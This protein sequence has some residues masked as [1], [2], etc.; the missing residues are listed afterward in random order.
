MMEGSVQVAVLALGALA[1]DLV[2][3]ALDMVVAEGAGAD[4][5]CI[6]AR[7]AV[8]QSHTQDPCPIQPYTG[9]PCPYTGFSCPYTR[10]SCSCTWFSAP[11]ASTALHATVTHDHEQHTCGDW[12]ER[13]LVCDPSDILELLIACMPWACSVLVRPY[14]YQHLL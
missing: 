10:L 12:P 3:L 5:H 9:P 6:P 8:L 7:G 1:A 4:V 11:E 14:R 13:D 2:V